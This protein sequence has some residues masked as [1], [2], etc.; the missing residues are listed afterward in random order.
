MSSYTKLTCTMFST[1]IAN[2]V[3]T[4]IA[5]VYPLVAK[6][7]G[8]GEVEIGLIF[9][10][11][12]LFSFLCSFQIGNLIKAIGVKNVS[13][14]GLAS[15]VLNMLLLILASTQDNKG[16]IIISLI[17]RAVGGFGLASIYVSNMVVINRDYKSR[18]ETFTSLMEAFG[19]V[20]L[21]IS[22]IYCTLVYEEIGLTGVFFFLLIVILMFIP[23]NWYFISTESTTKSPASR[24][25][26]AKLILN[27]NL[28]LDLALLAYCYIVL[29]YLEPTVSLFFE[30]KGLTESQIGLVFAAMASA[31]TLSNFFMAWIAAHTKIGSM[32][33]LGPLVTVFVLTLTGPVSILFDSLWFSI[34]GVILTGVATA[35]GFSTILPSM[36]SETEKLGF[37]PASISNQLSS[38]Y[39]MGMN[40]GEIVGPSISGVLINGL[41]FSMSC[42]FLAACGVALLITKFLVKT[43]D[44][45]KLELLN[46]ELEMETF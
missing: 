2:T 40:L 13:T 21:M 4:I 20:G 9:S 29:C 7:R 10:I 6:S 12:P 33:Y 15:T 3:I 41:G 17:G 44:Y 22:P 42:G 32:S 25:V 26:D 5:P 39:S 35:I 1:L 27:S 14:L 36:I 24:T 43:K 8:I 16:F 11:A 45:S 37:N 34:V 38:T 46:K 18:A 31:Y 28:K 19:G 30:G 23:I